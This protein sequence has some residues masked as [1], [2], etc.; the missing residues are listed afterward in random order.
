MD[1]INSLLAS[2]KAADQAKIR[3]WMFPDQDLLTE[4]FGTDWLAL[5]WYYNAIKTF[6]Y[7]HGTFYSDDEVR[8]LHYIVDKPW[9]RRPT[10][11]S[12]AEKE[13]TGRVFA[14]ECGEFEGVVDEVRGDAFGPSE[15]TDAVTHGWWWEAWEEVL[16]VIME[17]G[18]DT[19][20]VEGLV[21][22]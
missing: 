9:K 3:S 6:R 7:W 17:K 1:R 4:I 14:V 5:P 2:T 22:K 11:N 12:S 15:E 13:K 18:M 20:F 8:V 16:G 21:A 10:R 19:G